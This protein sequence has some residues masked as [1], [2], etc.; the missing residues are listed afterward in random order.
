MLCKIAISALREARQLCRL[1]MFL[2]GEA[3][4]LWK[5]SDKVDS[6][7][8]GEEDCG[9]ACDLSCLMCSRLFLRARFMS[10]T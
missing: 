4:L 6:S 5:R 8:R 1:E 7:K 9:E 10:W 3:E 2:P